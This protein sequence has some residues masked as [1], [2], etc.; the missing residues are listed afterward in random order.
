MT[1]LTPVSRLWLARIV[2]LGIFSLI[3]A[4]FLTLVGPVDRA[5][6][7]DIWKDPQY[8]SILE[9]I[10][11]KDLKVTRIDAALREDRQKTF[12]IM[13]FGMFAG[14]AMILGGYALVYIFVSPAILGKS[15]EIK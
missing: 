13:L 9:E 10:K 2:S 14:S 3:L 4:F 6:K 1:Y 11:A 15:D 7:A 8:A 5:K 12:P